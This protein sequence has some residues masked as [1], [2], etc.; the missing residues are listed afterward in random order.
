MSS[1]CSQTFSGT[2][3]KKVSVKLK[4]GRKKTHIFVSFFTSLSHHCTV[5]YKLNMKQHQADTAAP[6]LLRVITLIIKDVLNLSHTV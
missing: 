6:L 1:Q 4:E 3:S 5:L 2:L